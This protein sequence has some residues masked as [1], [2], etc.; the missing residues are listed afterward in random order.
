MRFGSLWCICVFTTIFA[1]LGCGSAFRAQ[2]SATY[3][4]DT[5]GGG[6]TGGGGNDYEDDTPIPTN[7]VRNAGFES[8]Y[9]YWEDWGS[10]SLLTSDVHKGSRSLRVI[11]SSTGGAGQEM[12]YRIKTGATYKLSAYGRIGRSDD[13]VYIGMRFFD[14]NNATIADRRVALT[15]LNYA[16][17]ET[18]FTVPEGASSAKVYFWKESTGNSF[19][20]VDEFSLVMVGSPPMPPTKPVISNPNNFRPSGPTGT[21]KLVLNETFDGSSLNT[22]IW[23]TGLWFNTTINNELQAY[24]P[25]NVRVSGGHLNLVAERRAAVTTWGEAMNYASGA[26]TTRNKFT[27]TFGAVEARLK[28]PRGKG[29]WP[30][31]WILPNGKRSPPEINVMDI[32]GHQTT[33][34]NFSYRYFDFEGQGR[35]VLGAATGVDF[36]ADFHT[37]TLEWSPTSIRFFVDG[38]LRGSYTG[39]SVLRDP[40]FILLNLAVGGTWPGSPSSTTI[41]P[42]T[43]EVDYVRVWQR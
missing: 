39:E 8:S 24:R 12:I 27:F 32:L 25:E 1:L 31:F 37:F 21:W 29:L 22:S 2:F 11:G 34:A 6:G 10:R 13:R 35:S 38:V 15:S 41:F 14:L 16:L 4:D 20:D 3:S 9:N 42:Q 5:V 7:L 18:T 19:A 28:S 30:A 23:N 40:G 43:Y 33:V 36:A 26:I 17:H